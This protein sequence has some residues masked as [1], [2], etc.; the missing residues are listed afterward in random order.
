M[1]MHPLLIDIITFC[2]LIQTAV[3]L[4][5]YRCVSSQPGCGKELSIR[6]ERWHTCPSPDKFGGE[7]FCVKVI[8]KIGSDEVI[9][10]EC[11]MTLRHSTRHREKLPT[12]QRQNYCQPGRNNDPKNPYDFTKTFCFCNDKDGCNSAPR[13]TTAAASTL[14]LG[15]ALVVFCYKVLLQ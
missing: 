8:E 13:K 1:K 11:L 6:L 2:I 4:Q 14:T 10:R 15:L 12:V 5:C 7:N 3:A 9:T